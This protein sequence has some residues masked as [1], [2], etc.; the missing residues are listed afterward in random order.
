MRTLHAFILAAV[1]AVAGYVAHDLPQ[2]NGAV[3]PQAHA[4]TAE[5]LQE[6]IRHPSQFLT[7]TARAAMNEP[8]V[9]PGLARIETGTLATMEYGE[10]SVPHACPSPAVA[11]IQPDYIVAQEFGSI[12]IACG[13]KGQA[14]RLRLE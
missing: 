5:A 3:T 13:D 2:L 8:A 10:I 12:V 9:L 14:F 7:P 1:T 6:T 4:F 11:L